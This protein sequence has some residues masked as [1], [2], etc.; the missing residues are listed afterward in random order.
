MTTSDNGRAA[1]P[2]SAP[3]EDALDLPAL[4]EVDVLR[5]AAELS[6]KLQ[7][8]IGTTW[9]N[10]TG[11]RAPKRQVDALATRLAA[12]ITHELHQL[13]QIQSK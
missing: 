10:T 3:A 7:W 12:Q 13:S 5:S 9:Y 6:R 8:A 11:R 1:A 4:T 2:S